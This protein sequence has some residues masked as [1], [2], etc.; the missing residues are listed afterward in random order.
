DH[1]NDSDFVI[2]KAAAL[3]DEVI[4]PA[5]YFVASIQIPG[6]GSAPGEHW[7]QN[8]LSGFVLI[9]Q[10]MSVLAI[11]L[12]AGLVI[13]TIIAILTKQV[14]QIGIMRS[15]GAVPAQIS[16]MFILN[17]FIFSLVGWL[18]AIPIGMAGSYG[19]AKFTAGYLN[20]SVTG[21]RLSLQIFLLQTAIAFIVPVGVA[22]YPIVAGTSIKIYDAIYQHG[23][24]NEDRK[25]WL[26][27]LLQRLKFLSPANVLSLLNTFRNVPRLIITLITLTL[28][29]ATFVAAFS[30]RSSLNVQID[31][32]TRYA[33]YDASI[34]VTDPTI[35][36]EEVESTAQAVPG[37]A[38]AEMWA[39]T[40]G[41]FI[42]ED[43]REGTEVEIIG[44]PP[45]SQTVDPQLESG[46]WLTNEDEF[47][48]VVNQDFAS[49]E[50][51]IE[52]G[53]QI[54]LRIMGQE[55]SF[56]IVGIASK[57]LVGP[58]IYLNR[59]SFPEIGGTESASVLV[60]VRTS[61]DSLAG[62][63]T[64]AAVGAALEE[65]LV[66]LGYTTA[67]ADMQSEIASYLS[68][69]FTIILVVL[70]LMAGLLAVVGGLS[71]AGTMGINVM[72][73]TRE[74]GVLRSVGA[75][76]GSVRMVVVLEGVV[77][78]VLSWLLAGLVSGPTAAGL[79]SAVIQAVLQTDLTFSY[80][81]SGLFIWLGIIVVI[82]ALSSLS[83][84]RNAVQL[85]VREVLDYE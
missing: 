54:T 58:R 30:T 69:P 57:H 16:G 67:E 82:G 24:V 38:Y 9:L 80:S 34:A 13:N 85:T 25:P 56:D 64:Q 47:G 40:S 39:Q 21:I 29:G 7:A 41:V 1:N 73:R 12:S 27:R 52:V 50:E 83:P 44:L 72:E 2:E 76:N 70:I 71:L 74:I 28:A 33:Q 32:F 78:A 43:Q 62:A 36:I 60:R 42:R 68:E 66:D 17:I 37:V 75:S 61:L 4:Q 26:E 59:A 3:R 45:G 79:A 84:A 81:F 49:D 31:E 6:I 20:F 10:V 18:M 14:K 65:S 51:S 53:G 22:I 15:I 11:F 63:E 5:G 46:R 48:V 19:L 35:P 55:Q 77:I 23:L 8:Q